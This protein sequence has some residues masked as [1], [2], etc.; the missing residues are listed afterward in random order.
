MPLEPSAIKGSHH[1]IETRPLEHAAMITIRSIL[2]VD[3]EEILLRTLR[4][5]L[6]WAGFLP[7]VAHNGEEAYALS[8]ELTFDL[9][10][11]DIQIPGTGGFEIIQTIREDCLLRRKPSSPVLFTTGSILKSHEDAVKTYPDAFLLQKPFGAYELLACIR[12]EIPQAVA[13]SSSLR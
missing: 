4:R 7:H 1:L 12:H 10:I 9:I 6:T 3:D 13:A 8:R 2:V 11:C 5:L